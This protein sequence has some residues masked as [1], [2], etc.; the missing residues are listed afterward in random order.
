MSRWINVRPLMRPF[1]AIIGT[2]G[3]SEW[4]LNEQF[5]SIQG[6]GHFYGTPAWFIRLQGCS[7]GC[8][9]CDSK[10]TW[11]HEGKMTALADI[12]QGLPYDARHVVIT[13]GEPFEQNIRRLLKCLWIEGRSVQVETSG[14]Y[15]VYGPA[16]I[17]VSPK[18]FKPLSLQALKAANEIKQVVAT[19]D[20]IARLQHEVLPHVNQFVPVYLQPVSNGSRAIERCI[21]ACKRYGYR[22]SLQTHKLIGVP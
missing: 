9:W 10:T 14:C 5:F 17:T 19:A 18:F 8:P 12:L 21:E 22:L 4:R 13:G 7:V 6:E 20:D 1:G 2:K 16:W 3:P 11:S 15:D